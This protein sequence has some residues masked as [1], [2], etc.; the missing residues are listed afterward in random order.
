MRTPEPLIRRDYKAYETERML[1]LQG[2]ELASFL[3]RACA[4]MIDFVLA[5]ILM[6]VLV[7]TVVI[8]ITKLF[9]VEASEPGVWT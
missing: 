6:A 4:L 5:I 7:A 1:S 3:L 2:A 9:G 8:P